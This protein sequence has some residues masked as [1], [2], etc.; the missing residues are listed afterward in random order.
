MKALIR[1]L[2]ELKR[3]N[4]D[5]DIDDFISTTFGIVI[6][7]IFSFLVTREINLVL[8]E[9][10]FGKFSY[11]YSLYQ[12]LFV[13]ISLGLYNSYL[14]FNAQGLVPQLVKFIQAFTFISVLLFSAIIYY[15]TNNIFSCFFSFILLYYERTYFYRSLKLVKHLNILLIVTSV[16]M[17]LFLKVY[18]SSVEYAYATNVLQIYGFSYLLSVL[19]LFFCPRVILQNSNFIK[20]DVLK[21]S[22]PLIGLPLVEWLLNFCNQ[23][24]IKEFLGF[25]ELASFSMAFR[26]LFVFRFISSVFLMFYPTVYYRDI[27]TKKMGNIYFFR[28]WITFILVFCAFGMMC[29]SNFIYSILGA[30]NYRE[31]SY[32]FIILLV[33]DCLRVVASFYGLFFTYQLKTYLNLGILFIASIINIVVCLLL[34]GSMGLV[35]AA[36]SNLIA[37]LFIFGSTILLSIKMENNYA[38]A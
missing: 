23:I 19:F 14:R 15:L 18:F 2:S 11:F 37:C 25:Q 33:G 21:F 27:L 26:A 22:L 17:F 1:I 35:S 30:N 36:I 32:I 8:N 4:Q 31:T 16:A 3:R 13:I 29:L 6:S 24:I 20:S 10:E 7:S 28:K 12:L 5:G 34:I 38:K 9:I